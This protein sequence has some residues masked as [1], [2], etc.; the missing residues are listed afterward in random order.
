MTRH[1]WCGETIGLEWW[2]AIDCNDVEAV[3]MT[4]NPEVITR[5]EG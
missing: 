1:G 3:V 5:K 4:K 2:G